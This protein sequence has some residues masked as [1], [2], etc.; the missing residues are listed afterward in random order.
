M[1]PTQQACA[2]IQGGGSALAAPLCLLQDLKPV[3]EPWTLQEHFHQLAHYQ[4][5]KPL[6]S[7]VQPQC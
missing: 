2:G 4:H 3:C 1:Q 5:M 7:V 6:T